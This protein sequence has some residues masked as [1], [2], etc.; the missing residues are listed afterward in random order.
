MSNN[1][2]HSLTDSSSSQINM[3][4]IKSYLIAVVASSLLLMSAL[5]GS[6]A[7][8]DYCKHKIIMDFTKCSSQ[9]LKSYLPRYSDYAQNYVVDAGDLKEICIV[10]SNT[11][12]LL[13]QAQGRANE[14]GVNVY[15][16]QILF[17]SEKTSAYFYKKDPFGNGLDNSRECGHVLSDGSH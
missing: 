2:T 5:G 12:G 16:V 15:G 6:K 10:K 13:F 8:P 1:H 7:T 3:V 11:E 4:Q 17:G 14:Y 9:A